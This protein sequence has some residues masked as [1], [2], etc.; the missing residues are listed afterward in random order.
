MAGRDTLEWQPRETFNG[1]LRAYAR[2]SKRVEPP[3]WVIAEPAKRALAGIVAVHI[4]DG[5]PWLIR[6]KLQSAEAGPPI[7]TRL[8]VEHY[9][10]DVEVTG[11][12]LRGLPAGE[13]RRKALEWLRPQLTI[14]TVLGATPAQKR[15]A[16]RVTE[17]AKRA[18][19]KRGRQGYP[20]NHYRRIAIR[21]VELHNAGTHNVTGTL[22]LELGKPYQTVRDWI[23]TARQRGFLM[24]GRQGAT[25]FRPGPNLYRKEK[26]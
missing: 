15:W 1:R 3:P 7:L 8:S 12:V 11:H 4:I 17:Q 10:T 25:D 13:I 14:K 26:D 6:G 22:A 24:P 18:P 2:G 5:E 20:D 21:C 23:R 9:D 16:K 19:L